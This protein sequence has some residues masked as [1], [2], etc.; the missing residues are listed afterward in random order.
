MSKLK[1]MNPL[2]QPSWDDML[3]SS[4]NSS[5]F[6]TSHWARVL[7]ES[8]GY[9]PIYFAEL[10]GDGFKT[11][12]PMMEVNSIITGKRGI[13]L[14]FTDHCALIL[15]NSGT[16]HE[17]M[18]QLIKYGRRSGW[19]YVELRPGGPLPDEFQPSSF[20]FGHV[21]DLSRITEKIYTSFRDSTKRNIKRAENSGVQTRVSNTS[22]AV[23]EF[24]R[25]HCMTRKEHGLPPQPYRFFKN[26][27]KHVISKDLGIVVLASYHEK[28]IAGAIYF[29]FGKTAIYKYGASDKRYQ[30][31]RP[32]N[33]VM[34]EA[35]QWYHRHGYKTLHFGRTEPE[36][37]GL[38]QFKRGWNTKEYTITYYKYN[39]KQESFIT[40]SL[41]VSGAHNR[42]FRKM[43]LPLLKIAGSMLYRH[44]A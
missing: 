11:L 31:F 16:F 23:K 26:I 3:L 27:Y 34:W 28:P 37:A 29:H 1:S 4:D 24:Y 8:Y 38:L 44:M 39:L 20:C 21:L 18:D 15:N 6:C 17:I 30:F 41:N 36:N 42:Y 22:N 2:S 33:L 43:P 13:S 12:I 9:R 7:S 40:D 10:G 14:P 35:V 19:K 32:N 5:F 25:L